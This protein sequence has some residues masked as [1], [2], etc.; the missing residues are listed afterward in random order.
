MNRKV[1]FCCIL[2]VIPMAASGQ[3]S[4]LILHEPGFPAADSA[5]APDAFLQHALQDHNSQPRRN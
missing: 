4:T 3:P 2:A 1:L 5:P